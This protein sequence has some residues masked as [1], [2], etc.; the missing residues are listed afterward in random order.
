VGEKSGKNG[1][2]DSS[3]PHPCELSAS[4]SRFQIPDDLA[5]D[6]RGQGASAQGHPVE[7]GVPGQGGRLLLVVGPGMIGIKDRDVGG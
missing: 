6:D 2:S 7:G 4:E 3:S 1:F 5:P